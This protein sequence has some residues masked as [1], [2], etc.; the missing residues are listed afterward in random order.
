MWKKQPIVLWLR[1]HSFCSARHLCV[2]WFNMRTGKRKWMCQWWR[3]FHCQRSLLVRLGLISLD[4]LTVACEKF[5][6]L[7][8]IKSC[9]IITVALSTHKNIRGERHQ[10]GTNTFLKLRGTSSAWLTVSV[11]V[12]WVLVSVL[13]K[14]SK[15]L[16]LKILTNG[17]VT[18]EASSLFQY[19]TTLPEKADPLL[20]WWLLS[21]STL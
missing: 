8:E 15:N 1:G 16:Y 2:G 12:R 9:F 7:L 20:R 5:S 3:G 17:S 18:T 21:Y 11:S 4:Y 14:L 13:S 19:F 10:T 6:P